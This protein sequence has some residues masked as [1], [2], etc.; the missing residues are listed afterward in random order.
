M[1][2]FN[3]QEL[4]PR[5]EYEERVVQYCLDEL[6]QYREH[7]YKQQRAELEREYNTVTPMTELLSQLSPPKFEWV[8]WIDIERLRTRFKN[9][10]LSLVK[11]TVKFELHDDEIES[12]IT[13]RTFLQTLH[14]DKL[15][16]QEF[17]IARN[18]GLSRQRDKIISIAMQELLNELNAYIEN[19][20]IYETRYDA[21]GGTHLKEYPIDLNNIV[22]QPEQYPPYKHY[23][24]NKREVIR[25][26]ESRIDYWSNVAKGNTDRVSE[27]YEVVTR[28]E[29]IIRDLNTK[30]VNPDYFTYYL[31]I[32]MDLTN[33]VSVGS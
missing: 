26:L 33:R 27:A 7:K 17:R 24:R 6:K 5:D 10:G 29:D 18:Y 22:I 30:Q 8:D 31:D 1:K 4:R 19:G 23:K 12:V 14:N 3:L 15:V 21:S 28:L 13:L 32:G 16:E 25:I 11:G 2:W 20:K 9:R